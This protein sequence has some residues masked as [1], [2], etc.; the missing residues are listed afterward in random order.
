MDRSRRAA[1]LGSPPWSL[2]EW[3][4]FVGLTGKQSFLKTFERV[5]ISQDKFSREETPGIWDLKIEDF[6]NEGKLR[7]GIC[8]GYV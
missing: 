5:G 7:R 8:L 4:L 2:W 3:V 1:R 6:R